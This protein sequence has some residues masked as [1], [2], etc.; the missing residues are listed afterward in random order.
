[1]HIRELLYEP[2]N[3]LV[4]TVFILLMGFTITSVILDNTGY[5]NPISYVGSQIGQIIIDTTQKQTTSTPQVVS[6]N[7]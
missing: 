5:P 1:M 6:L 4:C 3:F 7:G 2:I